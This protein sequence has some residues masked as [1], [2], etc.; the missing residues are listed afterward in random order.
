MGNIEG[1]E[2]RI[3]CVAML[4]EVDL[5]FMNIIN[6]ETASISDKIELLSRI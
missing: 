6:E 2:H 3:I 1:A 4:F 5:K